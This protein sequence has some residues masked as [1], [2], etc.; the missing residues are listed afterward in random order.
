ENVGSTDGPER[1]YTV[2]DLPDATS[3][4]FRVTAG[5]E[6]IASDSSKP[7]LPVLLPFAGPAN[8]ETGLGGNYPYGAWPEG[9]TWSDFSTAEDRFEVFMQTNG[10]RFSKIADVAAQ[11]GRGGASC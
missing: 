2:Y 6:D 5:S 10:G 9:L 8:V 4:L 11:P 1:Q 3:Y 7:T